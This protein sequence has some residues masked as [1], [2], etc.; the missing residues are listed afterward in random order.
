MGS[1]KKIVKGVAWT[2]ILNIVN[3]IYNFIAVPI[4]IGYFGKEQYGLIGLAMSINVYMRLMD[5]GLNSTNVRFYSA[6]LAQ[7]EYDKVRKSFQTSLSFY[8][9]IGLVNAV[10]LLIICAF[11]ESIFNVTPE[12]NV[13]LQHL[14]IILSVSAF[15]NWFSSCF[16]QLIKGTENVDWIQ[17]RQLI[18]KFL[19]IFVL[20]A[21]VFLHFSIEFYYILTCLATISIVPISVKKIKSEV[22]F[23]GFIP[24]FDRLVFKEMLPYALNIFSFS[25]FQFSFYHLRPVFLGMQGTVGS[26]ADYRILNGVIMAVHMIGGAFMPVLLP[27]ASKV[28]ARNDMKSYYRVAYDGTKYISILLCFCTFGMMSIGPDILTIYVGEEY[29]YL[30]PWFNLWLIC[31]LVSHNQAISSLILSGSDIRAISYNSAIASILGLVATWFLIPHYQI[32]GAV[33]GFA[34]YGTV[35]ML[36]YYLYYWP[37]KMQISSFRV[38]TQSFGPYLLLGI[39]I[40]IVTR[41]VPEIHGNWM[42]LIVIGMIFSVL[43]I[44]GTAISLNKNDKSFLLQLARRKAKR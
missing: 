38:F 13:I 30:I 26:V 5:M 27:S 1:S 35:Q 29:L 8:G 34:V 18:P 3:A 17:R 19:Q 15:C 41:F 6:W 11:S 40:Y 43:Y 31:N 9:C 37:K 32:G 33:I 7:K 23:V 21:T 10:I 44:G 16:D 39:C 4:L 14:L 22:P 20:F 42:S 2:T 36:F 12:Q 25:L 28:R 24:R